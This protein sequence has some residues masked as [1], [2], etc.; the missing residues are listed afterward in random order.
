MTWIET[1][2][3]RKFDLLN[4][5]PAMV[6]LPDIA[7]ALA[8]NVRFTGHTT[9]GLSVAEHSLWVWFVVALEHPED[10]LLQA[11]A[12][13][14][15]AAEA[16]TGDISG[17]LKEIFRQF[18]E[19]A[20]VIAALD[21]VEA[22]IDRA[23]RSHLGIAAPS[24]THRVL[25]KNADTRILATE[26]RCPALMPN[27]GQHEWSTENVEPYAGLL[28]GSLL[29]DVASI[30]GSPHEPP[31]RFP[32]GV[33]LQPP[34]TATHPIQIARSARAIQLLF[35]MNVIRLLNLL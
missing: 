7:H 6:H 18:A 9:Q 29:L 25:V 27:T 2:S 5:T 31:A 4:P 32:M 12:L 34:P 15:D 20:R 19:S 14:H 35:E 24:E 33:A 13:L 10:Y 21:V 8:R 23:I 11:H 3:G 30:L 16:Y 28:D 1:I 22:R 17:P 26:R